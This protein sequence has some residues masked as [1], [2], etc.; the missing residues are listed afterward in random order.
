[1]SRGTNPTKERE[2]EAEKFLNSF[3]SEASAQLVGLLH[4]YAVA[5][6]RRL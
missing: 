2:M 6:S 4:S 5:D 3:P 1:M